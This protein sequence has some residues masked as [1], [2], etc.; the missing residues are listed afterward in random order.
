MRYLTRATLL[1][2]TIFSLSQASCEYKL[3]NIVS[4]NETTIDEFISQ[5]SDEC[6]IS[7]IAND[8]AT[9]KVMQHSINKL[10]IKNLTLDEVLAL[11]LTK[12]NI[13]YTLKDNTLD[14]SYI[15]TKTY[16]INYILTQRKSSAST[17]VTLSSSKED[18]GEGTAS[19]KGEAQSGMKIE[20]NDE[21]IFWKELDIEL[22]SILN[23]PEDSYK[24][25]PPIINK[26]AG[27]I[28]VSATALQLERLDEYLKILQKKVQYQVL[29]D[30]KMMAVVFD[31][32][33]SNGVD[34]SQLYKL[35]NL[36]Y[37]GQY[38]SAMDVSK[39]TDGK[40]TEVVPEL[41]KWTSG[42][43][44]VTSAGSLSEV[45]KFLKTQGD[46]RAISNPKVLTLNNQPALI[47]V[48]TEY[49]YKITNSTTT[50]TSTSPVVGN[51]EII[52]SVF[53]GVLLDI[54]PEISHD[55]TITLKINPSIS[56]TVDTVLATEKRT[57]PPDLSRRQLSSVVT[58]K[59]GNRIILGGLI[60]RRD[61]L[62]SNQLPFL[63]DIPGLGYLFKSEKTIQKLEELIIV[64]EP[65][66]IKKD[67]QTISLSDLGYKNLSL[68]DFDNSYQKFFGDK[69]I[70]KDA[71][72]S[73]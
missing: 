8:S 24:A 33:N 43:V 42:L 5:L 48:G 49:F 17:D 14:I 38:L 21:V 64:I 28:T 73:E 36:A 30:V 66:I 19:N 51:T 27:M 50:A 62:D 11:I 63:G 47:T 16:N 67:A 23:R 25:S 59:D 37:T 34:W 10:Y 20:T 65:H 15:T 39:W 22:Q 55:D 13:N 4:S 7:V 57:M 18:S 52:S 53:A 29:I 61:E 6:E 71:N 1:I 68:G 46:L 45:V 31:D 54:T 69:N 40:I 2:A 9:K 41:G 60:S 26:N 3:F 70:T 32:T 58:V 44:D 72:K 56:E 35:Q 12:N